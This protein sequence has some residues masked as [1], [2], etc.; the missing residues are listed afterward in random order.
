MPAIELTVAPHP[1]LLARAFITNFPTT[2]AH[3]P[4]PP[5]LVKL[6]SLQASAALTSDDQVRAEVRDLLR[7]GGYRPTG[8]GK[9]AAEYL[10]KAATEGI[11]QPINV[12][13]D[14][15]NAVSLHSGLPISVVDLE[16]AQAP[17]QITIAEEGQSYA[18]N[19]SGQTIDLAGLLCLSDASGPC[20]N[21]VKD[22]QRTKTHEG[23]M[24][25]LSIVWGAKSQGERTER[26]LAW[27]RDLL[28]RVG[29]VTELVL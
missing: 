23:T 16:R 3:L 11:L 5:W 12:A 28:D 10:I 14:V 8:R 20:A 26:A 15:C 29:A 27:Y 1:L 22:A 17:F 2:L 4:A 7:H 21:A 6:L 19:A 9:P 25:T 13:V 18:F 24:R